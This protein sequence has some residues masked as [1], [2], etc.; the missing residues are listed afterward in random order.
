MLGEDGEDIGR[1]TT[2]WLILDLER[3]RPTRLPEL[4]TSKLDDVVASERP[5]RFDRL[6]ALTDPGF[7][8]TTTVSYSDLDMVHHANNAAFVQWMVESVAESLWSTHVP[9]ELEVH[10]LT[11]CRHG[12]HI[13]SQ[14]Q[15]LDGPGPQTVLHRLSR[16][17]DGTEAA[18]AR[19]VW[20]PSTAR[21]E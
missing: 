18:R 13:L 2:L 5:T 14:S 8:T 1:A 11:E 12:E 3:R 17:S 4:I 20:R 10:Y 16:V 15:L 19:T 6:P 7:E 9:A 21:D